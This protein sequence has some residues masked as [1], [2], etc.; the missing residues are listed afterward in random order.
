MI[1][2]LRMSNRDFAAAKQK[3]KRSHSLTHALEQRSRNKEELLKTSLSH[4]LV[5]EHYNL[6]L[7]SLA[8]GII[9]SRDI[10]PNAR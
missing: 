7:P 5:Q 10:G 1:E 6:D 4:V 3:A 8:E 2:A 9:S